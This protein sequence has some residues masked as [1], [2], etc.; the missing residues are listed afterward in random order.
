MK[1]NEIIRIVRKL[2][3]GRIWNAAKILSSYYISRLI[4]RPVS[5][6]L[7]IALSIEPTTA[8]NL[9]CPE[10]PSGLRSF[11]RPTGNLK[12]AQFK[13]WLDPVKNSICSINFY[14]QGEPYIHPQIHEAIAYASKAGIYT[15]SSTNGHFLDPVNAEKI[16]NSGLDRLIISVDGTTQEVYESYRKGGNLKKV[17]EGVQNLQLARK[18]ANK[19]SPFLI[20]QF[21][22]VKPNEHQ[23]PEIYKLA[24][25]YGIDEVK[26]KTAQIYQYSKG[27]PLIPE[28]EIYSRYKKS[29]NGDYEIKNKFNNHCWKLWHSPTITWDGKVLPCCFDKDAKHVLGT[30]ENENLD[31]VWKNIQFQNFRKNIL[32][33]RKSIDICL[34][35]T[36]G[37]KVWI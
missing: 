2:S 11:T 5:W 10:C 26:L 12:I 37:T 13:K 29:K 21:L 36:E 18:Q 30:L 6:G 15:M 23:I 8:C 9:H 1:Q 14:F 19:K 7:P 25:Q 22:V 17:L 24:K 16:V 34:N 3:F 31:T 27:S 33:S 4:K 20:F 35:C 28:Q 32:R